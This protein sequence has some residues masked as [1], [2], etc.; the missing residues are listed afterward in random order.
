MLAMPA[1]SWLPAWAAGHQCC[2]CR[3]VPQ[4]PHFDMDLRLADSPDLMALPG[5][6]LAVQSGAAG[7][8]WHLGPGRAPSELC[9]CA[10][11]GHT[12]RLPALRAAPSNPPDPPANRRPPACSHRYRCGQDAGLPQ[13]VQPAPDAQLWAA[14]AAAGH[15]ARQGGGARGQ[16]GGAADRCTAPQPPRGRQPCST[17][18]AC[19]RCVDP[20]ASADPIFI[21]VV[22]ARGLKSSL[23]DK[24]D[25][26]VQLELRK[27]RG[28][29]V[30]GRSAAARPPPAPVQRGRASQVQSWRR[31]L[32]TLPSR[33][34][35]ALSLL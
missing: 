16:A 11:H 17:N 2:A 10:V 21:Q 25:P 9:T 13:R 1:N 18:A 4:I 26:L 23:F 3:L 6:P 30:C 20:N 5:V 33:T 35:A 32:H 27:G 15:A 8:G 29:K 12:Y 24:V 7:L 19:C 34:D 31:T 28:A 22:S 14:A